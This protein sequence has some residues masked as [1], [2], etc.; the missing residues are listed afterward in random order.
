M[1]KRMLAATLLIVL[2]GA[3]A[4]GQ[5]APTLPES[6][7]PVLEV[8]L[9]KGEKYPV[10]CG[11]V[12]EGYD[13]AANGKASVST[14]DWIQVFGAED[15]SLMIQYGIGEGKMRIGW[16]SLYD[17]SE[18]VVIHPPLAWEWGYAHPVRDVAVT[19]DPFGS[20]S[21]IAR[22]SAGTVVQRL[23]VFGE[24]TYIDMPPLRGF[25]P[26]D[27]ME[28]DAVPY[29]QDE[30]LSWVVRQFREAGIAAE[31]TGV[32]ERI[33]YNSCEI[34]FALKNGGTASYYLYGEGID[35][36]EMNWRFD[37]ISD[38]DIERFLDY[39]FGVLSNVE[40]GLAPEEYLQPGYRGD[41][42]QRN[43]D[44]VISNG[45][46]YLEGNGDPWL[47]V[48]LEQLSRHDGND[49]LNSLR[50]RLVSRMLGLLDITPVDPKEGCAW[51][52]ALQ[53]S[54]QDALPPVDAGLYVD[55]PLMRE[56]TQIMIDYTDKRKSDWGYRRDID[57]TKTRNIVLLNAC[58]MREEDGQ[59]T[60]WAD[61]NESEYALYDGCR[62]Q[63]VSG[64]WIPCRLTFERNAAG[65]WTLGDVIQAQEGDA[66]APSIIAFCDG[67]EAL[68]NE[69][70]QGVGGDLWACF[71]EYLAA[72][73]YGEPERIPY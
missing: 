69:M 17:I 45:L 49:A 53:L 67:D 20:R 29:E 22:L 32:H 5:E 3:N 19:D 71:V 58:R 66:Y 62:A 42:G 24:W 2:A 55:D 68:A 10:Y 73:G 8:A 28:H 11:P 33:M 60:L 46:L 18:E 7:L 36:Y 21:E 47:N 37:G 1:I 26:T 52:D 39:Y 12:E 54:V 41:L 31:A 59:L 4:L 35:P 50:A 64:S 61:V 34:Y 13:R 57:G 6:M 43:I 30:R 48:L 56:L 70:M 14:N 51:Y 40:R 72:N 23:A 15:A 65:E 9:P 16:I 27:A 25:V 44:A 38:G 63:S